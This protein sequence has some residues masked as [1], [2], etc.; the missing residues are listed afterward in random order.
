MNSIHLSQLVPSTYFD[1]P[2]YL[3]ES[4]ILL[5]PD[6][7]VTSDLVKRL[8]KWKYQ[9]VF[10]D[11]RTK[12]LPSYQSGG[13]QGSIAPQTIDEDIRESAEVAA[14]QKFYAEFTAFASTLFA[15]FVSDGELNLSQV[16][17]WVKKAMQVV[18]DSRDFLLRFLDVSADGDRYLVTHSVNTT[19]LAL[20][21]ADYLKAPAHRLIEMGTP[22]SCTRSACSSCPSSCA[23]PPRSSVPRNARR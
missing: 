13:A 22:P 6:S 14:A 21:V 3:D 9:Q 5:T 11:G 18:H 15:S 20:A 19:I 12:D 10:S 4:Y 23:A 17:T 8:Q 1:K 7:P 16:T 2:V